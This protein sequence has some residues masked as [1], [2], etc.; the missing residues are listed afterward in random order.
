[1]QSGNHVVV[2]VI[3]PE[4]VDK[5]AIALSI[6]LVLGR[7]NI[8]TSGDLPRGSSSHAGNA[9]EILAGARGPVLIVQGTS[10][11]KKP[12]VSSRRIIVSVIGPRGA[13]KSVISGAVSTALTER[14]IPVQQGDRNR[15]VLP[16][17]ADAEYAAAILA[18]TKP[19]VLL[20]QRTQ[21]P[22]QPLVLADS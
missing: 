20:A 4:K 17:G 16:F 1:M 5:K 12:R 3:G 9:G 18:V 6:A 13:G 10:S 7:L 21:Q 15:I 19:T 11:H 22:G 2:T 14:G 8:P